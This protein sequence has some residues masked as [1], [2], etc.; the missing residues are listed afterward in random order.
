MMQPLRSIPNA[1]VSPVVGGTGTAL[2][3]HRYEQGELADFAIELMPELRERREALSRFFQRV[4]VGGRNLALPA[5]EYGE[6][7]GLGQRNDAW[8][9]VAM[10]L[11][12]EAVRKALAE[13]ELCPEDIDCVITTTV[14]GI[15]V[16][17]LDARLVNAI[18]FRTDV[19]RV[20]LFGLGCL[21]GAA[22]IARAADY[23]R[24]HPDEAVLLVSVELCSLTLQRQDVSTENL[25]STGLF[26]DGA[27]AVVLRGPEHRASGRAPR[28]MVR[29][30]ANPQ[31]V[32]S[33]SIFFRDTERTMGWDVV[34]SGFQVVLSKDVPKLVAEHVPDGVDELLAAHELTRDDIGTWISHPGGPAVIAALEEGLELPPE[35]L[36]P[37][38]RHLA[39]VGN[40]S[41][42]SVLFLLDEAR[43]GQPPN[44]SYGVLL[45]MGPGFCAELVLL[46]W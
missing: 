41:S 35:A 24:G 21:G 28:S 17:S 2:P 4:G 13:A 26:G 9:R 29:P 39:D 30:K 1:Q 27:A 43:G 45:A 31:V 16:P 42:S 46:R 3:P 11:S 23:L 8:L 5:H 33:R 40:L 38:R 15:A 34:D 36:E 18:G 12:S 44:G 19:K 25:I 20:P 14:T 10:E 7:D 37:T 22:G 32:D 6:L